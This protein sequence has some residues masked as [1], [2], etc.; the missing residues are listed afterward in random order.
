MWCWST[1]RPAASATSPCNWRLAEVTRLLDTGAL[2]L[3]VQEIVPF[4]QAQRALDLALAHHVRG[5]L[6]LKIV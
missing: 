1:R 3:V 6:V 2:R 4:D 5:K